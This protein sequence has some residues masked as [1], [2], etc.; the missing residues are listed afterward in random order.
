MYTIQVAVA[1]VRSAAEHLSALQC[2]DAHK[3]V[4]PLSQTHIGL[5]ESMPDGPVEAHAVQ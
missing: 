2:G 3:R 5:A 1:C 4:L